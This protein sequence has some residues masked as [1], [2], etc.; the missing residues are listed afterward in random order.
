MPPQRQ[1]YHKVRG[2]CLTCKERKV[3]CGLERPICNN[4]RR[5]CRSCTFAAPVLQHKTV[6]ALSTCENYWMT[7]INEVQLMHH[8]TAYTCL[9]IS[10]NP[11]LTSLWKEVVPKHA[12]RYQF[13]LYG[14]F[15][16]A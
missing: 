10:E 2:G 11:V 13:L 14:I 3:R 4:C 16:V 1:R 6:R 5:L 8:Y 7:Q 9:T 12:F 15:S